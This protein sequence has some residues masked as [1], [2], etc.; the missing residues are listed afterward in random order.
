[1]QYEQTLQ[2]FFQTYRT[3]VKSGLFDVTLLGV[4]ADGH[5]ASLF[6]HS[7]AAYETRRWVIAVKAPP[8]TMPGCRITMTVPRLNRSRRVIFLVSG[9]KKLPIAT[10]ILQAPDPRALP[11]PAAWIRGVDTTVWYVHV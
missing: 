8:G 6:P 11:Y 7:P 2:M 10:T 5:T 9:R 1:M 4:G 3:H